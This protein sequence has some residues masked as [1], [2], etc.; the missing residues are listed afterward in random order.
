[1]RKH[2]PNILGGFRE[3][4]QGKIFGIN[5]STFG[6]GV[7]IDRAPPKVLVEQND[8]HAVHFAGLH[9]VKISNI[10]SIVPKPPGNTPRAVARIAGCILR[11]A[12]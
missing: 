5:H 8:R 1:V 12:K 10:S 3:L 2:R 11:M 4:K 7:E 9:K 6:E